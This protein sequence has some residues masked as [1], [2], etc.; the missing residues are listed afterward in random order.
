MKGDVKKN[1]SKITGN[2]FERKSLNVL[3]KWRNVSEK[4]ILDI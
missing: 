2:H 4:L 1:V 3:E